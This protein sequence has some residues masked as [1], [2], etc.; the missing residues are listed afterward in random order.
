MSAKDVKSFSQV[1][2]ALE[3]RFPT[4][5]PE[6][7]TCSQNFPTLM[8]PTEPLISPHPP[9]LAVSTTTEAHPAKPSNS[10]SDRS[11]F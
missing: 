11:A 4:L 7:S 3:A 2:A 5:T 8:R 1:P 10:A 6:F 9:T